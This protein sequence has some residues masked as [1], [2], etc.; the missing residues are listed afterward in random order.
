MYCMRL[1]QCKKDSNTVSYDC[2]SIQHTTC[3]GGLEH[4]RLLILKPSSVCM[5]T[6]TLSFLKSLLL[7]HYAS[8]AVADSIRW[9]FES[10]SVID[11]LNISL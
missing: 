3:V 4:L 5:G 2:S 11:T 6:E 9:S 8:T 7:K 10:G 1:K